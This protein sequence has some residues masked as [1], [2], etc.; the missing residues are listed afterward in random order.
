[1]TVSEILQPPQPLNLRRRFALASLLIITAIAI[2]LGYVLSSAVTERMLHREGEVSMD[3]IQ[4]LLIT[5]DSARYLVAADDRVLQARFL[6]SMAHIAVMREPVRANAYG[7]DGTVLWS[8]DPHLVGQRF[9]GNPELAAA[10]QGELVVHGDHIDD[11][12]TIKPEHTG[13]ERHGT[14]FVESYIPIRDAT[15]GEVLGVIE[16]Y[17]V[18][19]VLGRGI[20][21]VLQQLWL[22]CLVSAVALFVTLYWIVARADHTLRDQRLR[23]V[24]AQSLA[25]AVELSG[26]VAHNLRNPLAAI[27]STAELLGQGPVEPVEL[28]ELSQDMVKAVDRADRWITELVHVAQVPQ[29]RAETVDL[30]QLVRECLQEMA[31][32]MQ[33]RHI[34]WR[35]DASASLPVQAHT[36]TMRQIL[37]SIVA[38]AMDAMPGGG[39]LQVHWCHYA[40]LVGVSL[41]DSGHGIPVDVQQRLFRPFFSTKDG[42]LGIGL[43]LVKR[44]VEHWHGH[45]LLLPA[46]PH[47]TCVQILLPP[48]PTPAPQPH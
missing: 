38:N 37:R 35:V 40:S 44:L 45:L 34:V 19:S 16:F 29:L 46:S 18:P 25:S 1:M 20:E 36:A 47:G 48:G 32:E 13:L 3:F 39:E 6:R 31:Q 4:N 15:G 22:A 12:G 41:S 42:G 26:A 8:T 30:N 9:A 5:D 28:Q 27:R 17:K 7:R 23:L 24:E 43:A 2:G 21:Q 11:D 33:R 14:Y 10:L